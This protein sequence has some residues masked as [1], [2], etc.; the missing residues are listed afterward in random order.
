MSVRGLPL[1]MALNR[2][3]VLPLTLGLQTALEVPRSSNPWIDGLTDGYRWGISTVLSSVTPS[4]A[5]HLIGRVMSSG[6][7]LW[8]WVKRSGT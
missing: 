6:A 4:S 8:G 7:I 2:H 3:Q 1:A 5:I